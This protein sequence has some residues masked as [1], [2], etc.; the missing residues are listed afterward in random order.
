[1]KCWPIL[2]WYIH[3]IIYKDS[4]SYVWSADL[5][6]CDIGYGP[7]FILAS[8]AN[9][10]VLTYHILVYQPSYTLTLTIRATHWLSQLSEV[11]TCLCL[12]QVPCYIPT[13]S[14]EVLTYNC[15]IYL[16]TDS[17]SC[18]NCWPL[19][20][21]YHATH[22]KSCLNCWPLCYMYHATHSKSCLNCWPVTCT[23][24]H[25]L[26]AVWTVDLLHVPCYTF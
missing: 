21:M 16:H 17:R 8:T 26:K 11:L 6:R 15:L 19:C 22:S 9:S 7:C 25:I 18:L 5:S 1:M 4:H 13:H 23:M 14:C 2:V 24:L 3:T 10:E 12:T 20:Y